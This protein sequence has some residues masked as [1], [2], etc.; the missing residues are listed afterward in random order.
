MQNN[1]YLVWIDLEMTG[2]NVE[3]DVI[4]EIATIITDNDLK[5]IAEGPRFVIHQ[6][7]EVLKTMHPWCVEQHGKSGLTEAVKKST[8]TEREAQEKTLEFIK[9]YCFP[10]TAPL[11]GNSVYQDKIFLRKYMPL[12]DRYVHYRI[13]D[14]TSIKECVRRWYPSNP[15][16]EFKKPETHR[17]MDDIKESIKELMHYRINFF[18]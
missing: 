8:I 10:N 7:N 2:L 1:N 5:I 15:A 9:E 3:T 12:I 4:L 14:V 6:S 11:C 13:I 17:A 16:T 18:K